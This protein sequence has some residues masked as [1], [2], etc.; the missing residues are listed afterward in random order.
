M[1]T[2]VA[3]LVLRWKEPGAIRPFKV[4]LYPWL[5]LVFKATCAYLLYS[6][7]RHAQSEHVTYVAIFV[8]I[9]GAL[10]GTGLRL[11]EQYAKGTNKAR[12]PNTA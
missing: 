1:L 6:S 3:L 8:M 10:V 11:H 4:P 9:S 7:I 2:G 12:P 5:P